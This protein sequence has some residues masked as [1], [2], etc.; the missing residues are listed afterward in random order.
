MSV[1]HNPEDRYVVL[2]GRTDFKAGDTFEL[3]GVKWL[4][5]TN[6]VGHV[7]EFGNG[8]TISDGMVNDPEN[9]LP[10]GA[11]AAVMVSD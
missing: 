3:H 8:I 11:V 10:E 1:W 7:T 9:P 4:A 5:I 2:T 6:P